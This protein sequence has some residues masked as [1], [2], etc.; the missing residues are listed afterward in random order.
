MLLSCRLVLHCTKW[1]A[2]GNGCDTTLLLRISMP[3]HSWLEIGLGE[4]MRRCS[5]KFGDTSSPGCC[6]LRTVVCVC[7][8]VPPYG[9][10][11]PRCPRPPPVLTSAR[12]TPPPAFMASIAYLLKL[13]I[14]LLAHGR[15]LCEIILRCNIN[16]LSRIVDSNP[17]K[18]SISTNYV[19]KLKI[20]WKTEIHFDISNC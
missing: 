12:T 11:R 1:D 2:S 17:K 15:P 8:R 13:L 5:M 18:I 10:D 7:V 3:R 14:H 9:G 20:N 6:L 19:L 4:A 16:E